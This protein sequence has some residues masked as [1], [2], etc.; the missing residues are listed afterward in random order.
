LLLRIRDSNNHAAWQ[1]F[2]DIYRP[3][4]VRIAKHRG[5][6]NAD[7]EDLAQG[8]LM[9]V[10]KAI[11]NW[12]PDPERASFRT[13]LNKIISNAVTNAMTRRKP[14]QGAGIRGQD[15][16]F[17]MA[18][19][20]EIDSRDLTIEVRR[21]AFRYAAEQIQPGFSAHTW[22]AFWLTAVQGVSIDEASRRLEMSIGAVYAARSRIM[23]QLKKTIQ[24]LQLTEE[25][26]NGQSINDLRK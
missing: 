14:D 6:Q 24:E 22:Q 1:E 12:E 3:A 4:I 25:E 21:E 16:L 26:E 11:E 5:M 13:W 17:D 19:S 2:A 10:A 20:A 8:V 9:S 18:S 23:R 7:A 15:P